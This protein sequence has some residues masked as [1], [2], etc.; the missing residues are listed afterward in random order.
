MT[1]AILVLT[2]TIRPTAVPGLKLADPDV[3]LEQYS[4]AINAWV[5]LRHAFQ[6][7]YFLENSGHSHINVLRERFGEQIAIC[8]VGTSLFPV[9]F[10]KG[11]GEATLLQR[12]I[13][14][15][16]R[17]SPEVY[18]VKCTGH[19]FVPGAISIL[20]VLRKAPDLVLRLR[21]DL[22]WADS[23]FFAVRAKAAHRLLDGFN[24]EIDDS[25]GVYF[26]HIL[27]RR[28]LGMA[29]EGFKLTGWPVPPFFR[30][31][32]GSTGERYD[33]LSRRVR[34]PIQVAAYHLAARLQFI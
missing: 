32:S 31:T 1:N 2:G 27:A 8:E 28:A 21:R 15:L 14:E 18:L 10:G 7:I 22:S 9:A 34:R 11:Y 6:Q 30:G 26:E 29:S 12:F 16:P 33:R 13:G 19:L 17:P 5:Q 24:E 23:R 20:Q 4:A 25:R 3:R